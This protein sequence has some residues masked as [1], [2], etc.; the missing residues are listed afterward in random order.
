MAGLVSAES[1]LGMAE[2]VFRMRP[3]LLFGDL[4]RVADLNQRTFTDARAKL[5]GA[6]PCVATLHDFRPKRECPALRRF[7]RMNRA[8][9]AYK[10]RALPIRRFAKAHLMRGAIHVLLF[11]RGRRHAHVLRRALQIFFVQIDEAFLIA[12]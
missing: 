12:A 7:A 3:A 5:S 11:E 6:L 4:H 10:K 8:T 9:A 2:I 1:K